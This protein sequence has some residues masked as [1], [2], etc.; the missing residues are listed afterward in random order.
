[1]AGLGLKSH[2]CPMFRNP[3][4]MW[5]FNQ[6]FGQGVLQNFL[7]GLCWPRK[8]ET[9]LCWCDLCRV[10]PTSWHVLPG[11]YRFTVPLALLCPHAEVRKECE[12]HRERSRENDCSQPSVSEKPSLQKLSAP[13][14]LNYWLHSPGKR[15]RSF[16]QEL[17]FGCGLEAQSL[18]PTTSLPHLASFY[19][20]FLEEAKGALEAAWKSLMSWQVL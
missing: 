7:V 10:S 17:A 15:D 9:W 14:S 4:E 11:D 3:P 1:M 12:I 16:L 19:H 20:A 18:L 8:A 2:C 6:P 13:S 5:G